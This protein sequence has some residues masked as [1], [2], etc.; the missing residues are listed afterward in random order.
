M[1]TVNK[2]FLIGRLGASPEI[3]QTQDGKS[4]CKLSL[5]TSENWTDKNTGEKKDKTEWHNIVIW[6]ASIV[7]VCEKYLKKGSKVYIEGSLQTR[8]Y[9]SEGQTKY[10]TEIVV[11]DNNHRL[12][13]L[14]SKSDIAP[15]NNTSSD[16]YLKQTN[17]F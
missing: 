15:S 3:R 1:S 6:N 4:K 17:G 14:D 10:I 5:A 2:V 8:K 16:D 7:S 13:M 9:E 11:K 12:T